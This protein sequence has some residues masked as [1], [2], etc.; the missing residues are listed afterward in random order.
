M[1]GTDCRSKA[2][3]ERQ[4]AAAIAQEKDTGLRP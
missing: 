4:E 3:A 1:L 2:E